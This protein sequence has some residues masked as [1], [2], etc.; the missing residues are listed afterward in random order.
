MQYASKGLNFE[1]VIEMN[2]L[3]SAHAVCLVE[4]FG[5]FESAKSTQ[6]HKSY[7]CPLVWRK[8]IQSLAS[9]SPVCALLPPDDASKKLIKIMIERDIKDCPEVSS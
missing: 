6:Q 9:S 3:V 7:Q 2:H 1:Q 8:F 5:F 4:L